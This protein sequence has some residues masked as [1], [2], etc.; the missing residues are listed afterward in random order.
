MLDIGKVKKPLAILT[1]LGH[2]RDSRAIV[3]L[4]ASHDFLKRPRTLP[5]PSTTRV[6]GQCTFGCRFVN[7]IHSIDLKPL[8]RILSYVLGVELGLAGF[9]LGCASWNASCSI[10]KKRLFP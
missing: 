10:Q 7:G 2:L 5:R 4:S 3:M 9:E 8:V 6:R 1:V